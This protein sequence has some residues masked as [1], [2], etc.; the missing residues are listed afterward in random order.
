M[1]PF[2]NLSMFTEEDGTTNNNEDAKII[3]K[4]C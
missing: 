4:R 2:F 1:F 3:K